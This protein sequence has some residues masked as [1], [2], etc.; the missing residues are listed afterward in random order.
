M[1]LFFVKIILLCVSSIVSVVSYFNLID[2]YSDPFY[3]RF[4]SPKQS[5]LII[6]SS[7]AAQGILPSVINDEFDKKG[8]DLSIYNFS[9]ALNYSSF[10]PSYYKCIKRKIDIFSKN[11]IFIIEVNPWTISANSDHPEDSTAFIENSLP[12]GALE[13]VNSNPNFEYLIQFYDRS[14][15][16][17]FIDKI[18]NKFLNDKQKSKTFLHEDGWIEIFVEMDEKSSKERHDRAILEYTKNA[19]VFYKFSNLRYRYLKLIVSYLKNF[20]EVFLVRMPIH[21]EI[22]NSEMRY[23]SDFTKKMKIIS[24]SLSVKYIDLSD[25][26]KNCTFTDGNHLWKDSGREISLEIAKAIFETK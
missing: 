16:N 25:S 1:K 26:S 8:I 10:G 6:G 4:A 13:H 24:E 22:L 21:E 14:Y 17:I 5:S 9:F 18:K 3:L 15:I 7:R 23:M 19:P 20:G 12:I 11:S 2:G